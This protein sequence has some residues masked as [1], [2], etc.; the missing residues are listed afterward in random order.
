MYIFSTTKTAKFASL[1]QKLSMNSKYTENKSLLTVFRPYIHLCHH[2]LTAH[3]PASTGK[4][5]PHRGKYAL[6][7]VQ[8]S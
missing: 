3:R 5:Q 1:S 8:P 6:I 4:L 7:S 2:F